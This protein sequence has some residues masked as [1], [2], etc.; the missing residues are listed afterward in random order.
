LTVAPAVLT[1]INI[2]PTAPAIK[3]GQTQQFTATG[4]YSD[5]S[6]SDITSSVTWQSGN[7]GVATISSSGLATGV[8]TSAGS[9]T[10]QASSGG[11]NS[12]MATLSVAVLQ[13]IAITP[14]SSNVSV[15]G[16]EQFTATG[17]Y[18]DSSQQDLTA[19]VTWQSD[20]TGVAVICDVSSSCSNKGQAQA[21]AAGSAGVTAVENGVIS[22]G[23]TL[24]VNTNSATLQSITIAPLHSFLVVSQ[25]RQFT[26]TGHFTDGS[27]RNLTALVN[28]ASSKSSV[29]TITSA[30]VATGKGQG[31]CTITAT[32]TL[33]GS[34]SASTDLTVTVF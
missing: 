5:N 27:T 32:I 3:A 23:A 4:H 6:T 34:H 19:S 9:A 11:V 15:G 29:A 20:H 8:A 22:N 21:L 12:N 2:T 1:S 33:D 13:T 10:I 31:T 28:W 7:L 25:T 17:T 30:G 14:G 16:T 24:A 26:A 18:S